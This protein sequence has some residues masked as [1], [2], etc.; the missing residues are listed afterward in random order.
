MPSASRD[1]PVGPAGPGG[2]VRGAAPASCGSGSPQ[3]RTM[4][5]AS[6]PPTGM[7]GSGGFGMR[8][9][10]VLELGL[11]GRQLGVERLDPRLLR[12]WRPS[13]RAATSGPAGAAPALIASPIRLLAASA[14]RGAGPTS[15]E[16]L[17]AP[18]VQR[19]GA[20]RRARG[21]RPSRRRPGGRGRRPRAAAAGRCSW[22]P[23]GRGLPS[24]RSPRL[25][26]RAAAR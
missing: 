10:S 12:R 26:P 24:R 9:S 11:G 6:S 17:A 3:V 8:S 18:R 20:R 22:L 15:A 25:P 1:L 5:L 13:R 2:A 16:Q 19:E 4:T 23:S 14:R 7:P 21:P